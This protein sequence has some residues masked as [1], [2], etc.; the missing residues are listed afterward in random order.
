MN[1]N[2]FVFFVCFVVSALSVAGGRKGRPYE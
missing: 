2:P 1:R